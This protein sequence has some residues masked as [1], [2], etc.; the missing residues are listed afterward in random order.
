MSSH[1][2]FFFLLHAHAERDGR[3]VP[4]YKRSTFVFLSF[5]HLYAI[6]RDRS[7][8]VGVCPWRKGPGLVYHRIHARGY[9]IEVTLLN[10]GG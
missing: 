7:Q 9:L 4:Y 6:S 2:F 5:L 10:D 8:E 3:A 1:V